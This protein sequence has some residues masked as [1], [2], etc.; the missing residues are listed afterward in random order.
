VV[1][2]IDD[3]DLRDTINIGGVAFDPE[4]PSAFSHP[5]VANVRIV[6]FKGAHN[7]NDEEQAWLLIETVQGDYLLCT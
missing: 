4:N 6:S 1:G 7:D 2:R 5:D 3:F